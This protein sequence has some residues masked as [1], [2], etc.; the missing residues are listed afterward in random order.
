MSRRWWNG[1]KAAA[2]ATSLMALATG[3]VATTAANAATEIELFFPVPVDGH[4]ARDMAT[5]LKEFNETHPA[6]KATPLYTG[7]YDETPIKTRAPVAAAQPPAARNKAANSP[8]A[9]K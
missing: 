7:P 2:F 9:A 3:L 1:M 5:L 4:L 6:I 8:P